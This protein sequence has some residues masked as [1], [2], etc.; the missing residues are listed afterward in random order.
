LTHLGIPFEYHKVFEK[1]APS[2]D[3][4]AHYSGFIVLGGP[5]R[6]RVDQ[7]EK[8]PQLTKEI[9]F[10]RAVLDTH[11]PIIA[12]SQGACLL[13]QAQGAWVAREPR[14]VIGWMTAEIYPDYARNSVIYSKVEEKKFPAFAW[15]D[16]FHGFPPTGYWYAYHPYCR[17][18]SSGI[19]G[20]S[21]LFN[22]HPEVTPELVDTWLKEY[23]SELPDK[24]MAEQIRKETQ[25]NIEYTKGFAHKII[26]AFE[27][28]L[29]REIYH[30]GPAVHAPA[31]APAPAPSPE[32]ASAPEP[33]TTH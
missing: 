3:Q 18:F 13:A 19:L 4:A 21:Y 15:F 22:F 30:K 24:A 20:S 6:F 1:G 7:T 31:P 26:H 10:L 12:V 5:L 2:L 27:S 32:G 8:N 33:T 25:E 14:K 16:T 28:F 17:Y 9:F 23:A 11:K 29:D